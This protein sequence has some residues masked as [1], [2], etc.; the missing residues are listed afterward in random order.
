MVDETQKNPDGAE[1]FVAPVD[2]TSHDQ[3]EEKEVDHEFLQEGVLHEIEVAKGKEAE[4]KA[5]RR[6]RTTF[7]ITRSIELGVDIKVDKATWDDMVEKGYK[8]KL[9][10]QDGWGTIFMAGYLKTIDPERFAE[11]QESFVESKDLIVEAVKNQKEKALQNPEEWKTYLAMCEH[12]HNLESSILDS[13]DFMVDD[14]VEDGVKKALDAFDSKPL[15]YLEVVHAFE[16]YAPGKLMKDMGV[17]RSEIMER[18][19]QAKEQAKEHREK[20]KYW[21]Y[22]WAM[23]LA[24]GVEHKFAL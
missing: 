14:I 2:Q 23:R 9:E 12:L 3:V 15:D 4:G 13:E 22:A 21:E 6:G 8:F 5:E 1:Q 10:Q 20:R 17:E 16:T 24:K 11:L 7:V 19:K 18:V